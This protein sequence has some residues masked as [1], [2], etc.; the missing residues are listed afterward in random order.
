MFRAHLLRLS[1]DEHVVIIATHH[2]VSDGWSTGVLIREVG[3]L[4]AAFSKGLP[5]SLAALAVQY[6][7]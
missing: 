4:Y 7:D 2:I 5:S 6:A 3:E 1:A